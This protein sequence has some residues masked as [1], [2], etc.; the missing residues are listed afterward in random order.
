M[1]DL[2]GQQMKINQLASQLGY[3]LD[4]LIQAYFGFLVMKLAKEGYIPKPMNF[5]QVKQYE[6]TEQLINVV[7]TILVDP[8]HTHQT[9]LEGYELCVKNLKKS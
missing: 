3:D 4:L 9:L 5:G 6:V 8:K 7:N 2:I 1:N